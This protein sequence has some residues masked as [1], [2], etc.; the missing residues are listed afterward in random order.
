MNHVQF[1]SDYDSCDENEY[2]EYQPVLNLSMVGWVKILNLMAK[3]CSNEK[4]MAGVIDFQRNQNR[5]RP[6]QPN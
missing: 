3:V 6:L 1:S 2:E 4:G 5:M